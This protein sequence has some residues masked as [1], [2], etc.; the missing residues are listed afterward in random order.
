MVT[1]GED[2]KTWVWTLD[3]TGNAQTE[4]VATLV[5][6]QD[7]VYGARFY[8]GGKRVVSV[9]RESARTWPEPGK[10]RGQTLK[11]WDA[12][13]GTEIWDQ[14]GHSHNVTDIDIRND[15]LQIATCS[16]DQR[17]KLWN[18]KKQK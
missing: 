3:E 18:L 5:G 9:S 10:K 2:H 4:P 16:I 1:G 11:F 17:V 8:D 15:S 7:N 13:S 6:H 14:I 12:E